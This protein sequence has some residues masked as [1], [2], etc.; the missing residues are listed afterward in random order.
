MKNKAL[1]LSVVVSAILLTGC[2]TKE[3][4]PVVN[5]GLTRDQVLNKENYYIPVNLDKV[6][7]LPNEDM[8]MLNLVRIIEKETGYTFQ[9]YDRDIVENLKVKFTPE[10]IKSVKAMDALRAIDKQYEN[11]LVIHIYEAQQYIE[12]KRLP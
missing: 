9:I 11:K 12:I 5:E 6:L 1:I 4:A 8:K 3:K 10:Q 2:M 7:T